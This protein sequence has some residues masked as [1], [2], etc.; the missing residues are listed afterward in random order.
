VRGNGRLLQFW[1]C[2]GSLNLTELSGK[3]GQSRPSSRRAGR[4]TVTSLRPFQEHQ[5]RPGPTRPGVP[6]L[7]RT[8]SSRAR[9]EVAQKRRRA[10]KHRETT[11]ATRRLGPLPSNLWKAPLTEPL[12]SS[13]STTGPECPPRSLGPALDRLGTVAEEAEA[14]GPPSSSSVSCRSSTSTTAHPWSQGH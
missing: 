9:L 13:S 10:P 14:A 8:F 2:L 1:N 6:E 5:G 12:L 11:D 7:G 3:R 4:T